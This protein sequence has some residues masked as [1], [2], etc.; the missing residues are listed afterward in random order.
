MCYTITSLS[1][2]WFQLFPRE[3]KLTLTG[4]KQGGSHMY[5]KYLYSYFTLFC[6]SFYI[7]SVFHVCYYCKHPAKLHT[8]GEREFIYTDIYAENPYSYES[9]FSRKFLLYFL[10]PERKNCRSQ[11]CSLKCP[12]TWGL[13]CSHLVSITLGSLFSREPV[14]FRILRGRRGNQWGKERKKLKCKFC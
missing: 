8:K 9:H 12:Q 11:P 2:L 6:F 4:R 14:W 1:F 3:K 13:W 10:W 5:T 7:I